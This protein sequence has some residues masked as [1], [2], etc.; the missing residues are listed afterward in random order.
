MYIL[1]NVFGKPQGYEHG[2]LEVQS[3]QLFDIE[4][5]QNSK[6][7]SRLSSC[8]CHLK[9]GCMIIPKYLKFCSECM[10]KGVSVKGCYVCEVK[11]ECMLKGVQG[12]MK[13]LWLKFRK[14]ENRCYRY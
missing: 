14:W 8:K 10:L 9:W 4:F 12:H 5:I 13:A 6:S 2:Y 1:E 11:G 3:I 7:F